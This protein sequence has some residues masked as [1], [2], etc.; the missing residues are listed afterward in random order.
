MICQANIEANL[1]EN[2]V[3]FDKMSIEV[4]NSKTQA[5]NE[6]SKCTPDGNCVVVVYNPDSFI[7]R[8]KGPQGSLF[9]PK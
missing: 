9:E 7:L 5:K 4:Y 1:E 6:E 8:I 3:S 2:I